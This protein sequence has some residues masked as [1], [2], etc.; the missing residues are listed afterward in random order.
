MSVLSLH[1]GGAPT[2]DG[3]VAIRCPPYVGIE[4]FSGLGVVKRPIP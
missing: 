1:H 4:Q 2:E 3:L